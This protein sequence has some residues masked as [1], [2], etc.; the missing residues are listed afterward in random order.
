MKEREHTGIELTGVELAYLKNIV[1]DR[2]RALETK[3]S[4][5]GSSLRE[6]KAP[7]PANTEEELQEMRKELHFL[8]HNLGEKLFEKKQEDIDT[9]VSI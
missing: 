8:Q 9:E 4:K 5:L 2:V 6:S 7:N 3:I 1:F